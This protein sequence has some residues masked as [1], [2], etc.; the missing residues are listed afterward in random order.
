M[1]AEK[2]GIKDQAFFLYFV[3]TLWLWT[4]LSTAGQVV[5]SGLLKA[6]ELTELGLGC[7]LHEPT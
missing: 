4:R 7:A 5:C 2:E 3:E 6:W 1:L